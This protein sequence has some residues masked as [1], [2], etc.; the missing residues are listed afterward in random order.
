MAKLNQIIAVEKSIKSKS[1][2]A[3]TEAHHQLQKSAL[4]SGLSR[5][6]RPKDDEGE[7]GGTGGSAD[8]RAVSSP[9]RAATR[10]GAE[11]QQAG[12]G[13]RREPASSDAAA[14]ASL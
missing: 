3:L 10:L 7:R 5:T 8:T 1:Y 4:L 2:A 9:L 13:G 11:R 14:S 12:R 6:Y